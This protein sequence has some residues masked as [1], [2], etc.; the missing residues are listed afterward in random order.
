MFR[1][2][3]KT[4]RLWWHDN[5]LRAVLKNSSFMFSSNTIAAGLAFLN[6]IFAVRLIGIEGLGVVA[7]VQTFV[8]NVNRLLSF[9]MSEVVV[10]YLGQTLASQPTEPVQPGVTTSITQSNKIKDPQ[11]AALVK[12]I[13]L[14]EAAT[15][16]VAYL[17]LLLLASWAASVL[18]KDPSEVMLIPFYGL[19]LI[20]NLVYETS[21]GVLQTHKRFDRLALINTIQSVLTTSLIFGAFILRRGVVEILAAYLV[22]KAF[23]G[24]AITVFAFKQMNQ[25]AGRGWWRESLQQ[26]KYWKGIWNFA[27]NTNLNGTVNLVTRDNAPLYL[28]Y[29]SPASVAQ[30]Y[31]GYLKLGLS[32]INFITLPIDPFIWPT[33]AEITRTIAQHLWARTR[34]LLKQVSSIAGAWTLGVTAAIALLGWWLIPLV[35]GADAAPVYPVVL[36]LLVGY[37]TANIFNWNRPLLLAFGKPSYPLRVALY[38]GIVEILLILWLVPQTGY[39]VMAGILSA[40]LAVSVGITAWRGWQELRIQETL[41]GVPAATAQQDNL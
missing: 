40:Y 8:S 2:W 37:G 17:V 28:T 9:R 20:A 5:L 25:S 3:L 24:V 30:T 16:I 27:I 41:D 31:V 21:T 32:I 29:L 39:L 10:K 36:V 4:L 14:I 26:V 34:Y 38:V 19:M 6:P 18:I 23:A 12:G 33:Y 11:A 7:I 13:G 22:G 15:S 35:Y 1:S